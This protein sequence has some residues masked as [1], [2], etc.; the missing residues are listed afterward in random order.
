MDNLR[1]PHAH[2]QSGL[3][4]FPNFPQPFFAF[5]PLFSARTRC[6]KLTAIQLPTGLVKIG[7]D[8]FCS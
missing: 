7:S 5:V 1:E 3:R 4:V 8:A 2:H 6:E